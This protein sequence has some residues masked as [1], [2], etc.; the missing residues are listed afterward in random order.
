MLRTTI[1]L[2]GRSWMLMPDRERLTLNPAFDRSAKQRCCLVP[3]A[4]RSTAPAQ[5]CRSVANDSTRVTAFDAKQT[6]A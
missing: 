5:L 1:N 6:F 4:L 3:V 2:L